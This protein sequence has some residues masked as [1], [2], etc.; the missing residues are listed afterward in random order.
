MHAIV[1]WLVRVGLVKTCDTRCKSWG[2][3]GEDPQRLPEAHA[4]E[5]DRYLIGVE[6]GTL[7][8]EEEARRA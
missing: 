1:G 6:R 7:E 8:R 3:H 4:A 5:L 2:R